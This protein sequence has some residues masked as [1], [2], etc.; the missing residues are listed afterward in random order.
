MRRAWAPTSLCIKKKAALHFKHSVTTLQPWTID[1]CDHFVLHPF[2]FNTLEL[3]EHFNEFIQY[4][5]AL[6]LHQ[7]GCCLCFSFQLLAVK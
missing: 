4:T 2:G 7:C 3:G 5:D 6:H 1:L